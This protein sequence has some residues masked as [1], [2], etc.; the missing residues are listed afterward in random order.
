MSFLIYLVL[1]FMGGLLLRAFYDWITP[2]EKQG[3]PM[4]TI[5]FV[6]YMA[7][8]FFIGLWKACYYPDGMADRALCSVLPGGVKAAL[9]AWGPCPFFICFQWQPGR[10]DD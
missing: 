10:V 9:D 8:V 6:V 2:P 7:F 1:V 5:L 3:G 4:L